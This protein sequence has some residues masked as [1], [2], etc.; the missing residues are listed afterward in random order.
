MIALLASN[1]GHS[2]VSPHT[3]IGLPL[4]SLPLVSLGF[5]HPPFSD[6]SGTQIVEEG[7]LPSVRLGSIFV[8]GLGDCL[9]AKP[10]TR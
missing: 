7:S 10:S 5:Q 9:S 6:I 8:V 4:Q 1:T 2:L 3:L